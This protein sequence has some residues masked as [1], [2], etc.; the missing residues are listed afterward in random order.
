[1]Q[2]ATQTPRLD[3]R[4]LASQR[5]VSP[6]ARGRWAARVDGKWDG[7]GI[8]RLDGDQG[9]DSRKRIVEWLRDASPCQREVGCLPCSDVQCCR[10]HETTRSRIRLGPY[11]LRTLNCRG[12]DKGYV[13]SSMPAR[14]TLPCPVRGLPQPR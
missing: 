9:M 4:P 2:G 14:R 11:T 3:K 12:A 10:L 8:L 5:T 6:G 1:M 7:G 13:R